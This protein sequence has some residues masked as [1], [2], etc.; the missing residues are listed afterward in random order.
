MFTF[1]FGSAFATA[2]YNKSLA[3][4]YFNVAMNEVKDLGSVTFTVA[5]TKD[6][7]YSFVVDYSTLEAKKA[8]LLSKAYDLAKASVPTV[9]VDS[10]TDITTMISGDSDLLVEVLA[11]QYEADKA[12]AIAA[13]NG[14]SVSDFSTDKMDPKCEADGHAC[15]T[16][17]DHVKAILADAVDAINEATFTTDSTAAKYAD[18]EK[19]IDSY[20]DAYNGDVT[21]TKLLKEKGYIGANGDKIGLGIY[22]INEDCQ[23]TTYGTGNTLE[24]Y[25]TDYIKSG[26]AVTAADKAALKAQ[27][28]AAYATY[29]RANT[30]DSDKTFAENMQKALN[31]LIDEEVIVS[32][33]P[34][35]DFGTY[36]V[37]ATYADKV[38]Y[39]VKAVENLNADAARLAAETDANGVL[40][41]DAKDV[42]D[43]VTT[44]T[45]NIY[46]I[47]VGLTDTADLAAA[48]KAIDN[49]AK[50]AVDAITNLY[51]SLDD[52]MLAY[53]KK[54]AQ[55][56]ITNAYTDAE[57]NY[58][59]PEY[60][61]YKA[62]VDEYVAKIEAAT[63]NSEIT[64]AQ[65]N[66]NTELAKIDQTGA[67]DGKAASL[68]Q[69]ATEYATLLN[70]KITK[71]DDQYFTGTGSAKLKAEINKLVGNSE[72]RTTKEINNL[73]D[74]ALALVKSLPTN[75]AVEAAKD[76][77]DDAVKAIPSK[78]STADK[79]TI[80]TAIAAV[81]AYEELSAVENY[82]NTELESAVTKYAYALNNEM[83]AKIKAVSKTDKEAIKALVTEI[84]AFE[85]AYEG[86]AAANT[87]N[88]VLAGNKAKLNA[89]LADIQ[90]TEF[91][92]VKAAI[93]AIPVQQNITEASRDKVVAARTLYDAYVAEYTD[94]E[95][96]GFVY[97]TQKPSD[98][99]VADDFGDS[100]KNLVAAET[101]LGLNAVSPAELVKGLKITARSTAAKGSITVK[102]TVKGEADIDGYEIWKSTKANK[103]YKKAFTT[104]KKTYK[105]S[106]GLKKGT[107]YYY[108]VRAYKV[109]DGV[110]V[111]S[112]W[113]NKANRKAK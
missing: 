3:N 44:G 1:S 96:A 38:D 97:G 36:F 15:T 99:F 35:I 54:Y 32:T 34:A 57:D 59:A 52:A 12:E 70:S 90:K 11:A 39:A 41:R 106:K 101:V 30:E 8:D 83:E 5:A 95:K 68:Y 4:E 110:K 2:D 91:D 29:L 61:K 19:V 62:L 66:F 77:A 73:S 17:Q 55:T 22:E 86:Y 7:D 80:D 16:Y 89:Y 107:R 67:I 104:T 14:V 21:Y 64:T 85:N 78:I 28:A 49:A 23:D 84:E 58:Y 43:E 82:K 72:A 20:F 13:L 87:T 18:A 60:A 81:D 112:D 92:A 51:V 10:A 40:V 47:G 37:K 42:A 74:Q 33:T 65:R 98:G 75:G 93:T 79:A 46:K 27:V 63:K 9:Y 31:Y 48:K 105:N 69:I 45:K 108:K 94:Y 50:T 109:I 6:G 76:A 24:K 113:S 102:W 25:T 100:Y 111:T 26:D 53:A 103:G 88:G 56:A 71:S